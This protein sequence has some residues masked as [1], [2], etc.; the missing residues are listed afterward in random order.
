MEICL[1]GS[2]LLTEVLV[3]IVRKSKAKPSKASETFQMML[4]KGLSRYCDKVTVISFPTILPP[5]PKG[6]ELYL[7]ERRY[8]LFGNVSITFAPVLNL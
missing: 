4:A 8:E 2:L 1:V 5:Y 7:P 6:P 3:D